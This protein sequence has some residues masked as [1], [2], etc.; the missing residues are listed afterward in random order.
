MLKR[1]APRRR[2]G[3]LRIAYAHLQAYQAKRKRGRRL[4]DAATCRSPCRRRRC[5]GQAPHQRRGRGRLCHQPSDRV[6][7]VL[8][9]E[10]EV[11]DPAVLA[12]A[13]LHD[14]VKTRRPRPPS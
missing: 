1:A 3:P 5:G 6:A 2:S 9:R 7:N 13:L 14:T 11:T 8:V 4:S 10:G 12:A